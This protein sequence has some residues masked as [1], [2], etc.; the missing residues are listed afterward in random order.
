VVEKR[1]GFLHFIN[2]FFGQIGGEDEAG[3][4]PI[5]RLGPTGPGVALEKSFD[6]K[7]EIVATIICGDNYFAENQQEAIKNIVNLA[8]KYSFDGIIAGP[9]FNSGRYGIAC[10]AICKAVK[11]KFKISAVTGMYPEN[12]GVDLYRKEVL[13]LRT[14]KSVSNMK[15]VIPKLGKLAIKMA[16]DEKLGFP[17]DEGYIPQGYKVNVWTKEIGA[18]RAMEML[19]KKMK[20]EPFITE[21]PMPTFDRVVPAAP[22]SKLNEATIALVTTGGIVPKGNPDHIQS[23]NA[24]QFSKYS[25][26]GLDDLVRDRYESIHAGYDTVYAN[27]DPDR[28]LPL[29]AMRQLETEGII[30]KL[31]D[32]YYATVGN[33]TSISNAN[34]FGEEIGRELRENNVH[35][36]ILTST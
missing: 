22:I 26:P 14:G 34:R 13:I 8:A 35:G 19:L 15:S 24:S 17:E 5:D 29:D 25:I 21:M 28:V 7:A 10:G 20:G 6:G 12:P 11:E 4:P 31:Y 33:L 16:R 3:H 1:F 36:V 30:G 32:Y 27:E 2:Q 23:S 9:A 18:I